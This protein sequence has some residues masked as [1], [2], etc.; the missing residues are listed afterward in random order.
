MCGAWL[1]K[2][3]LNDSID[4]YSVYRCDG[5]VNTSNKSYG[6]G[7]LI[8][9]ND[10]L[11]SATIVPADD[12][13]EYLFVKITNKYLKIIIGSAYLSQDCDSGTHHRHACTAKQA[14]FRF[15][16]FELFLVGY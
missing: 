6:G 9:V 3:W 11:I 14:S 4:D 8:A 15:P 1:T 2:T 13:T 5:G 12:S 7:C 16:D 10:K